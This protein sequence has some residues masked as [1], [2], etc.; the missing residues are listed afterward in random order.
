MNFEFVDLRRSAESEMDS[1]IRARTKTSSAKNVSALPH[2]SCRNKYLRSNRVARA[3]R[4][5]HQLQRDPVVVVLDHIS[6]ERG[7]RVHIVDHNIGMTIVEEV[8]KRR[9]PG[10]NHSRE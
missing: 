4:A 1:Q 10:G 6:E 3:S 8:A 5:S 2:P 7:M 9:S